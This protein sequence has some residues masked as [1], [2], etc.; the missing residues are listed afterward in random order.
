MQYRLFYI[1]FKWDTCLNHG[2][3]LQILQQIKLT[4]VFAQFAFQQLCFYVI[5]RFSFKQRGEKILFRRIGD[6]SIIF[7]IRFG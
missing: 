6:N 2:F 5:C 7:N 4:V 3:F 1:Q